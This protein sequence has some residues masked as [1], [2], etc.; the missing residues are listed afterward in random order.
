VQS[1]VIE[2][3]PRALVGSSICEERLYNVQPVPPE[4]TG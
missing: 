2:A 4:V 3:L 1:A